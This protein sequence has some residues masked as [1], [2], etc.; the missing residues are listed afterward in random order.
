MIV[1]TVVHLE[2]YLSDLQGRIAALRAEE[3]DVVQRLAEEYAAAASAARAAYRAV[4]ING[5]K[6]YAKGFMRVSMT[7]LPCQVFNRQ[8]TGRA[9]ASATRQ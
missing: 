2:L 1:E 8:E 5:A 4:S 9:Q 6:T 7:I 3:R